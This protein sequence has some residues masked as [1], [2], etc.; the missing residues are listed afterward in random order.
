MTKKEKIRYYGKDILDS[1]SIQI[2]KQCLQ[3]GKRTV[4]EHS[5]AVA[6]MCLTIN[7]FLH[8]KLNERRLIRGALLHDYFLYDWHVKDKSHRLHG[9]R[10]PYFALENARKEY[11]LD[12]VLED[13]IVKHM[14]P[15]IPIPPKYKESW[16]LCI[17]DKICASKETILRK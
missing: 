6:L 4:F 15:L 9:F 2:Q 17:A 7:E 11:E 14:F 12:P 16:V 5:L 10:H 8:L 1:K 13:M 3:H